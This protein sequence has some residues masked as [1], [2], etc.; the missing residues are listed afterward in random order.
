MTTCCCLSHSHHFDFSMHF[1]VI[2]PSVLFDT[3]T[4]KGKRLAGETHG[5]VRAKTQQ[6]ADSESLSIW[7]SR[8]TISSTAKS[9]Q[10]CSAATKS[11]CCKSEAVLVICLTAHLNCKSTNGLDFIITFDFSRCLVGS[12][13]L[14]HIPVEQLSAILYWG[15]R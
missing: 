14:L 2:V 7:V 3:E 9:H 13:Y 1:K 6:Y 5:L 11:K 4:K 8:S 15:K 10:P 12:S